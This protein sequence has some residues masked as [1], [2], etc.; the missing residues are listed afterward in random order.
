MLLDLESLVK[1]FHI[2]PSGVIHI[3]AHTGEEVKLYQEL[4]SEKI[5]MHLFEPQEKYFNLLKEKYSS[6][7]NIKLYNFACGAKT[8]IEEMFISS[9]SG[10]SSSILQPLQHLE[11]HPEIK[12]NKKE[13]INLDLLD[14]FKIYDSDFLNIDVQGYELNVLRG[15]SETILRAKYIYVEVNKK[16]VYKDAG[17]INEIDSFLKKFNFLRVSTQYAFDVL[18]WGDALYINKNYLKFSQIFKS[19]LKIYIYSFE[20]LYQIY[21][22]LRKI[23]WKLILIKKN[24]SKKKDRL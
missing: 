16:E 15:G 24:F 5:S 8:S 7:K 12:F 1:K 20:N 19:Y 2:S 14:N 3:G 4:F 13:T 6:S 18:P 22:Y 10:A 17:L 9:N 11:I 23:F 21:I